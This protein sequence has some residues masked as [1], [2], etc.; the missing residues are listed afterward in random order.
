MSDYYTVTPNNEEEATKKSIES[1]Y[2]QNLNNSKINHNNIFLAKSESN[3]SSLAD[4]IAEFAQQNYIFSENIPISIEKSHINLHQ[5]EYY[6][7]SQNY[8]A[9]RHATSNENYYK[10]N[11]P[12][13]GHNINNYHNQQTPTEQSYSCSIYPSFK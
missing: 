8:M 5:S 9:S 1:Y 4:N 11:V 6:S 3:A 2:Q 10:Y 12:Y 13:Y 7:Q